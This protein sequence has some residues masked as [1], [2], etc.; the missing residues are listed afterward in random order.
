MRR[1][2]LLGLTGVLMAMALLLPGAGLG[3]DAGED[4]LRQHPRRPRRDL[5]DERRRQ[6]P[7]SD[8]QHPEPG[9]ER[10]PRLVAGRQADRLLHRPGQP[11]HRRGPLDHER[12]RLLAAAAH[13]QHGRGLL[14]R[15]GP[16]WQPPGIQSGRTGGDGQPLADQFGW[17]R[18]TAAQLLHGGQWAIRTSLL[19]RRD[20]DRLHHQP[21][22]ARQR[23]LGADELERG[24][25]ARHHVDRRLCT[26]LH[27]R[28]TADRLL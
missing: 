2:A 4:R 25:G 9:P 3:G 28:R 5:R 19:A 17:K 10:R 27:G 13:L 11:R 16:G 20:P 7:D 21:G 1:A 15:L 6:R 8:H 23:L 14:G 24:A 26:R 22:R 12:R 18:S